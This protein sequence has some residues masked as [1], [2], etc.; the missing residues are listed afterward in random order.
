MG[1]FDIFKRSKNPKK[2]AISTAPTKEITPEATNLA[3]EALKELFM[4][5]ERRKLDESMKKHTLMALALIPENVEFK[6]YQS[7]DNV[8]W[9]YKRKRFI[10]TK[11]NPYFQGISAFLWLTNKR[12]DPVV[13]CRI[14]DILVENMT[15]MWGEVDIDYNNINELIQS[16][17]YSIPSFSVGNDPNTIRKEIEWMYIDL[18]AI[19][20]FI[21]LFISH[22]RF[23]THSMDELMNTSVFEGEY[24]TV[25]DLLDAC[26]Y[27]MIFKNIQKFKD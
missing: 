16:I 4:T 12:Q 27:E 9:C 14:M 11:D 7:Y 15:E 26:F 13:F 6:F 23:K 8:A 5:P 17:Q 19:E 21:H 25:A 10:G 3:E 24:N 20:R 18:Q 22:V 1:I 2:D